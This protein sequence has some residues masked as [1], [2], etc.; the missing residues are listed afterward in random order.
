MISSWA[1]SSKDNID[2][3]DF[4]EDSEALDTTGIDFF[5]FVLV[6]PMVQDSEFRLRAINFPIVAVQWAPLPPLS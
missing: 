6:R 1:F 5:V 3:A 2:G 4:T